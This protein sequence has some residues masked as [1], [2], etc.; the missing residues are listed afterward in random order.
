MV[1]PADVVDPLDRRHRGPRAGRD[2]DPVRLELELADA[3]GVGVGERR[4]AGVGREPLVHQVGDPLVLRLLQAFLPGTQPSEIDGRA[5]GVDAHRGGELVDVVRQ[6]R[7][8]EV[9]LRRCAGNV[10]AAPT[11][12]LALDERHP[13]AVLASRFAG[14]VAG[15]GAPSQDDQIELLAHATSSF[16]K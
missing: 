7:G 15:R 13:R 2:Q 4:P 8:D 5:P 12:A 10:R 6:L 1:D 11:P 9:G 14:R 3:H 16:S